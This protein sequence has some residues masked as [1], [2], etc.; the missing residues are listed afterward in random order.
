MLEEGNVALFNKLVEIELEKARKGHPIPMH[1][2]HEGI[3]VIEEEF[4]ELRTE[5]F[6]KHTRRLALLEE[7]VQIAAMCQRFAEDLSII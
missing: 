2:V 5:V 1:S 4:I 6:K 3:A 7:C